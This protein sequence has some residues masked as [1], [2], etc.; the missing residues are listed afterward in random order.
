MNQQAAYKELERV[1][2]LIKNQRGGRGDYD[3]EWSAATY[4]AVD[5]GLLSYDGGYEIRG[6]GMNLNPKAFLQPS[7]YFTSLEDCKA[8]KKFQYGGVLY[9][10]EILHTEV[11]DA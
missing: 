9:P 2:R 5:A 6:C 1:R 8:W 11:V 3:I 4:A 7:T 10:I